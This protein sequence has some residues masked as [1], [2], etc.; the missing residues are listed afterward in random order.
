LSPIV[1]FTYNRL[2][3]TKETI[4]ALQKNELANESELY[5]FSDAPKNSSEIE[6]VYGVREYLK[7]IRGF[8]SIT[9]IERDR[10]FG[11][12]NSIIEGVSVIIKKY[13]KV[14]VVEDDLVT[15]TNF[16]LF[17]NQALGFYETNKK[18]FSI[19]GYTFPL[20]SLNGS[21]QDY[22]IGYRASSWGWGTW[23]DRWVE[24]DWDVSTYSN[25]KLNLFKQYKFTRGGIDLPGMLKKQ[26]K[27][28]IN[29]W[30]IRWCYHQFLKNTY[31]VFP[32]ISKVQ[33]IGFGDDATHTKDS[34][35]FFTTLDNENKRRF[36][37]N[38]DL[39]I[40]KTIAREFR[41]KFSL[42]RR[43]LQD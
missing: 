3:Q 26:M 27:G 9:I 28:Q 21:I 31:T 13:Q 33:N 7:T 43:F 30:A 35:R 25:F 18:V 15:S 2:L 11:L 32:T 17:M 8:K 34:N 4:E 20:K 36:E 10:N 22:Y 19:S 37:F 29:S 6:K 14:I 42:W 23:E 39:I 5:I 1:I 12:A 41:S 38:E 40:N 16:L 24:I